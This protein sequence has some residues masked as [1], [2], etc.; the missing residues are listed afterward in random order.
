VMET[1]LDRLHARARAHPALQRLAVVSR[2]LLA[3]GFIPTGLVKVLGHRF[4]TVVDPTDPISAFFEAMYQT[5]AYWRF[6]GWAQVVA[7]IC[8][9]VPRLTTLGAVL[10]LPVLAN[11]FVVT[12]ALRFTGTPVVVGLMLLADVFLLCWDYDRLKGILWAP[13]A[14]EDVGRAPA[15][16][17]ATWSALERLGY[18]LGT[19]AALGA[20][21]WTRGLVPR[22]LIMPCL[23]L[24]VAAAV[25]VIIAWVRPRRPSALVQARDPTSVSRPGS[26]RQY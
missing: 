18:A 12:V 24:G 25:M 10:F 5:G 14:D 2:I 17:P 11:I 20:F 9:L 23:I 8:V 21:L 16:V 6:I 22:V 19:P 3:A 1:F 15:G 26:D 13:R 4:T 7:G